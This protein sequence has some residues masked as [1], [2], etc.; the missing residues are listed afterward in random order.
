MKK[1]YPV[2]CLIIFCFIASQTLSAQ[3]NLIVNNKSGIQTFF[4]LN[5]IKT[6]A[7]VDNNLK[8]LKKDNTFSLFAKS[9]VQ[10][11]SFGPADISTLHP[12]FK[13]NSDFRF[14][15]YPT[16]AIH[17]LM[18]D[19]QTNISDK[20]EIL[21]TDLHARIL[22]RYRSISQTGDNHI[23]LEIQQL[24]P[25]LYL[26]QFKSGEDLIMKKFVKQ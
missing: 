24:P 18:I 4:T 14:S 16:P 6:I 9:N 13:S 22:L 11:L 21:I 23:T 19:Y 5:Y 25:G 3:S 12:S 7:F 8:V 1:K 17:Q 10:Q 15:L 26:V 2:L 20:V